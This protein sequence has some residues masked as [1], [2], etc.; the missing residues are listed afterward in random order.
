VYYKFYILDIC[1]GRY[2]H[3]FIYWFNPKEGLVAIQDNFNA[4]FYVKGGVDLYAD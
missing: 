2:E 1:I 4:S 3:E